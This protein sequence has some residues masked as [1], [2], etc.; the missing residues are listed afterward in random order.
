MGHGGT[1]GSRGAPGGAIGVQDTPDAKK[2]DK[3]AE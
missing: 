2:S 3:T 1:R